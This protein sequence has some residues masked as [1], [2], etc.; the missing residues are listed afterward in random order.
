[1]FAWCTNFI[2]S[3]FWQALLFA[4][5]CNIVGN[6]LRLPFRKVRLINNLFYWAPNIIAYSIIW[7]VRHGVGWL[8]FGII[9]IIGLIVSIFV[10]VL[11]KK[12]KITDENK[13]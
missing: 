6:I 8:I 1:M 5:V 12:L 10:A 2:A 9:S 3:G 13:K 4:V 11:G 7:N